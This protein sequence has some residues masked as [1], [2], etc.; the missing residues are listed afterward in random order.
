MPVYSRKENE[1]E[2]GVKDR[3]HTGKET[4]RVCTCVHFKM[5]HFPTLK[6]QGVNP[7]PAWAPSYKEL[8]SIVTYLRLISIVTM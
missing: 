5:Q 6:G 1:M 3:R 8:I 7:L 2:I 4:K